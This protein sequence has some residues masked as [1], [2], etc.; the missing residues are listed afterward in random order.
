MKIFNYSTQSI[1]KN[2]IKSVVKTLNSKFLTKGSVTVNFE[3]KN[4]KFL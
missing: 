4:K 2:D 1:D 3:K